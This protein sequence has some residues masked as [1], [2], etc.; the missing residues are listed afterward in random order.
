MNYRGPARARSALFEFRD[1]SLRQN[2]AEL[3]APL[4]ERID[5]P[6]DALREDAVLVKRDQLAESFGREA[7]RPRMRIR[8][9]IAFKDSVRHKPIGRAFASTCSGVL[10]NASASACAKTFASSMS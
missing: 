1:D 3:H 7:V 5:V 8:R 9:A 10:P 2:L 4:I 6:D